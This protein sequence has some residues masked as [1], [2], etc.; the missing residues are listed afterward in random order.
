MN[1]RRYSL[2][3]CIIKKFTILNSRNTII[4]DLVNIKSFWVYKW[5]AFF[6][7]PRL[8]RLIKNIL[9]LAVKLHLRLTGFLSI[10]LARPDLFTFYSEVTLNLFVIEIWEKRISPRVIVSILNIQG[11][12]NIIR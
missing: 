8:L 3:T 11:T 9:R 12:I 5:R 6:F 1:K 10:A 7:V 4:S 2:T